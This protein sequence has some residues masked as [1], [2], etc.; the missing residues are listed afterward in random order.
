VLVERM[1]DIDNEDEYLRVSCEQTGMSEYIPIN[2]RPIKPTTRCPRI[3]DVS[4]IEYQSITTVYNETTEH[5][6]NI[7]HNT[8]L[9]NNP[10]ITLKSHEFGNGRIA[11]VRYVTDTIGKPYIRVDL[12]DTVYPRYWYIAS[13]R[14]IRTAND[15]KRVMAILS[16]FLNVEST[17]KAF[18]QVRALLGRYV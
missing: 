7:Q 12:R 17:Y 16:A 3:G 5:V 11:R 4:V 14:K 15:F 13:L 2:A 6:T 10:I 9:G 18:E 1:S 8:P